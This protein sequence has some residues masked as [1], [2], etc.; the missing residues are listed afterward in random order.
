MA[1]RQGNRLVL[2]AMAIL[3]LCVTGCVTEPGPDTVAKQWVDAFAAQDGLK[4][5]ELTCDAQQQALNSTGAL[6]SMI[7]IV[8]ASFLSGEKPKISADEL[9][10]ATVRNE[11]TSA[12]VRITGRIRYAVGLVSQAQQTD[13]TMR[14]VKERSK[15]RFCGNVGAQPPVA[16]PVVKPAAVPTVT[17]AAAPT[18]EPVRANT[19]APTV[20]PAPTAAPSTMK[21]PAGLS[22]YALSTK[23]GLAYPEGWDI[24]SYWEERTSHGP[25]CSGGNTHSG[26]GDGPLHIR[27]TTVLF[28]VPQGST[29]DHVDGIPGLA[30]GDYQPP[31]I[32]LE[33][34]CTPTSESP[35][36]RQLLETV[37]GDTNPQASRY[38]AVPGDRA[39]FRLAQPFTGDVAA[40]LTLRLFDNAERAFLLWYVPSNEREGQLF[41]AAEP[42]IQVLD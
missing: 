38:Q 37:V 29:P 42:L 31:Y 18:V 7:G 12:D 22:W 40:H 14:M 2:A 8:S 36:R 15:W 16:Q 30:H 26:G 10:Y 23:L 25:S 24:H 20:A 3:V 32:R 27:N 34:L 19:P 39:M 6:F 41:D 4:V 33:V 9:S 28:I 13:V 11:G 1:G 35:D 17:P 5:G 21:V